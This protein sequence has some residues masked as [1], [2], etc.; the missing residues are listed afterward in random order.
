MN[1]KSYENEISNINR[2]LSSIFDKDYVC[3]TQ[4]CTTGIWALLKALD[5]KGKKIIL[6]VNICF[7]VPCAVVL[8]GNIP[9]FVD[10]D[11]S[12][13]ASPELLKKINDP[14]IVAMIYPYNNGNIGQLDKIID[15]SI[16][17]NW[18]LIEDTA[19]SF[20]AK[21]DGKFVGS[22][23]DYAITS[24]GQGKILDA[25]GG[26]A[27]TVNDNELFS[28]INKI[29]KRIP[30]SSTK[31][32]LYNDSF[33]SFYRSAVTSIEND[34]DINY[35]GKAIS[36]AFKDGLIVGLNME[37][38]IIKFLSNVELLLLLSTM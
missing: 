28:E 17:K 10:I 19:Q 1:K 8:S 26:G 7:V 6:P 23:S 13:S 33:V 34:L 12:F 36:F 16:N 20:G 4:N 3:F 37:P 15:I 27:V 30:A 21:Y 24:F 25:G 31:S 32:D 9:V 5:F 29:L 2:E 14:D 38:R 22:F 11:D 18:V 35:L